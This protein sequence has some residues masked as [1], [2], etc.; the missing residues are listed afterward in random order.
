MLDSGEAG[1]L[2]E[3]ATKY[4]VGHS[5]VGRILRLPTLAPDIIKAILAGNEPNGLSLTRLRDDLPLRW[6]DQRQTLGLPVNR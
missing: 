2:D 1:S 5:Y 4:D 3:L 6:N